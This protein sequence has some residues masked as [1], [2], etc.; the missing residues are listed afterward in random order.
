MA[1]S[2]I[3]IKYHSYLRSLP[4]TPSSCPEDCGTISSIVCVAPARSFI[5]VV[6]RYSLTSL[7]LP[8]KTRFDEQR[9][10]FLLDLSVYSEHINR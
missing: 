9:F 4:S 5:L 7:S 8:A 10:T 1:L 6:I 2:V 3:E